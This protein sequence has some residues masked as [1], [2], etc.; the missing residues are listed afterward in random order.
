MLR[1]FL[2]EP[3]KSRRDWLLEQAEDRMRR[4]RNRDYFFPSVGALKQDAD[5][6]E[7]EHEETKKGGA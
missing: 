6:R 2:K 1:H 7:T 5:A 3:P 4:W